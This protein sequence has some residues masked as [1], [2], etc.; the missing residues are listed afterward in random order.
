MKQI[1]IFITLVSTLN[2]S[3]QKIDTIHGYVSLGLSVTNS[4]DFLTSTYTGIETGITYSDFSFGLVVGRGSLS[5]LGTKNDHLNNYFL[6]GKVGYSYQIK[7][8]SLTPFIGYGNYMG[9]NHHFIEYGIGASYPIK[10]FS[11]GVAFSSWDG[12]NYL[13]PNLTYNF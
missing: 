8:L 6:E 12:T 9:T 7:L 5:G 4:T 3:S 1:I 13:T 2:L 11:I 10:R